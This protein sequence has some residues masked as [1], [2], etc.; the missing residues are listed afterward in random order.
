MSNPTALSACDL[1]AF[2]P[3]TDQARAVTF[4]RDILGLRLVSQDGFAAVFDANGI[5]LRVTPVPPPFTPQRFTILGWKVADIESKVREL[6]AAG[7]VFERYMPAQ[8]E[9][10]IWAAP[11]GA[12]VAWFQDPDGNILSL[13]Q[14]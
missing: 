11:G 4:Y 8:D 13:T 2:A 1:V 14:F 6:S 10:G 3:V 12:K 9:L 7:V 5:M